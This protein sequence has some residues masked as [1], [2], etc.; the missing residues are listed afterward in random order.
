MGLPGGDDVRGVAAE[1]VAW[2]ADR[3]KGRD[4]WEAFPL[5]A[6]HYPDEELFGCAAEDRWQAGRG[7]QG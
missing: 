4:R 2:L 7:E 1:T 3:L 5:M 6:G